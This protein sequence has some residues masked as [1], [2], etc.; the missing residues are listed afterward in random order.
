MHYVVKMSKQCI[1][2]LF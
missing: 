2:F 1:E